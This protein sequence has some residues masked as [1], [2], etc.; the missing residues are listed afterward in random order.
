MA[1]T[2]KVYIDADDYYPFWDMWPSDVYRGYSPEV[3]VSE[4][5]FRA[6]QKFKEELDKWQVRLEELYRAHGNG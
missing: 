1:K 5:E 4:E 6:Y 2:I 3:E